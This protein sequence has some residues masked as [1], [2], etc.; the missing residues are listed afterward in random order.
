MRNKLLKIFFGD[1]NINSH[2]FSQ[3]TFILIILLGMFLFILLGGYHWN[4]YL[5]LKEQQHLNRRLKDLFAKISRF[6]EQLSMSA[7]LAVAT[8]NN[9]WE[10]QYHQIDAQFQANTSELT[11]LTPSWYVHRSQPGSGG[12]DIGS[13]EVEQMAFQLLHEDKQKKAMELLLGD[14]YQQQKQDYT[15]R[16]ARFSSLIQDHINTVLI[17]QKFKSWFM[18]ASGVMAIL[19]FVLGILRASSTYISMQKE[20]EGKLRKKA[21][22]LLDSEVTLKQTNQELR[23]MIETLEEAQNQLVQNEKLAA[24]GRIVAG[25]AHE[26]NTPVG[27]S[28]TAVSHMQQKNQDFVNLFQTGKMKKSDLDNFLRE[29]IE[30]TS[31][32]SA[33]MQQ[34][35]K[36]I[37]SFKQ[38]SADQSSEERREFNVK[39][40]TEEV[41]RNLNPKLKKT[42]LLTEVSTQSDIVLDS[43]PG[44][45]AQLITNLVVNSIQHAFEENE[46]GQLTFKFMQKDQSILFKYSDN[47]KGIDPEYIDKI[48]D[49]FFTTRRGDGGTGLGLHILHNLVTTTLGG[50]VIC[51]SE[52]GLG[53][54]FEIDLPQKSINGNENDK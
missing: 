14:V 35:A 2:F 45:F 53:T 19:F 24:L 23:Q 46:S 38:V 32:I 4:S 21:Q 41:L 49:P 36:L 12:E 42:N 13:A 17:Q 27:V 30:A 50:K 48:F 44:V 25:V 9:D 51:Y 52:M 22:A 1:K 28:V 8:G 16:I 40:Y 33:N 18:V 15:R 29:N 43:Y 39:D 47:G 6:D 26:I 10:K 37:F 11:R 31:I 54:T 3:K 7:T 20:A 5:D 34:A